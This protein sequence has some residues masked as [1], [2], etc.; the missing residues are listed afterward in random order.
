MF[1]IA[2]ELENRADVDRIDKAII[3][4]L[5]F[6]ADEPIFIDDKNVIS[7]SDLIYS[8]DCMSFFIHN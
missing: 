1:A 4:V 3:D 8:N 5:T 7:I 6:L 2:A